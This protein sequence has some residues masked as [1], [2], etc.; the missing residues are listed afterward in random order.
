MLDVNL[1][2]LQLDIGE[3][4]LERW[5]TGA[6]PLD[7][8]RRRVGNTPA[9]AEAVWGMVEVGAVLESK[10]TRGRY[11]LSLEGKALVQHLLDRRDATTVKIPTVGRMPKETDADAPKPSKPRGRKG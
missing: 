8:I 4:L 10:Q 5:D 11:G 2:N 3:L 1:T 9:L 6:V 7:D